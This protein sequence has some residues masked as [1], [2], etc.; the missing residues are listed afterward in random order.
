MAQ[1]GKGFLWA[2]D[3]KGLSVHRP[4][5]QVQGAKKINP[6][7]RLLGKQRDFHLK[8]T[9]MAG[10]FPTK[11]SLP[12][13]VAFKIFMLCVFWALNRQETNTQSS[14]MEKCLLQNH[15]DLCMPNFHKRWNLPDSEHLWNLSSLPKWQT[16]TFIARADLSNLDITKCPHHRQASVWQTCGGGRRL[17]PSKPT[18]PLVA[19][20]FSILV[21]IP[22]TQMKC[23][24]SK[25]PEWH[26]LQFPCNHR[27]A[28]RTREGREDICD[29]SLDKTVGRI[30]QA[31]KGQ[32]S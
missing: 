7:M 5:S 14:W 30:A 29:T 32:E 10:G 16:L 8:A 17:L 22:H 20:T 1:V 27:V 6:K 12:R 19:L 23:Y 4:V 13:N 25:T 3:T 11:Y 15:G 26:L 31:G 24:K 9:Q 18:C 21:C 2:S 28:V